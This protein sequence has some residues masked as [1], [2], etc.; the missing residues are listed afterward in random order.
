VCTPN[1]GNAS[2]NAESLGI[3]PSRAMNPYYVSSVAAKP[4][5]YFPEWLCQ[6]SNPIS[7]GLQPRCAY[8]RLTAIRALTTL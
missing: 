8:P 6:D 4:I 7:S 2:P 1:T 3:E 5:A